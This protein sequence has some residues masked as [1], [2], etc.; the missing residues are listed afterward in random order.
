MVYWGKNHTA[1]VEKGR[2]E[3]GFE[4]SNAYNIIRN[5]AKRGNER[6][7]VSRSEI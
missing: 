7:V 5:F 1:V 2:T 6:A 3:E 4:I